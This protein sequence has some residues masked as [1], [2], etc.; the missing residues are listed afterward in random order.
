[1]YFL[2]N[3]CG[4]HCFIIQYLSYIT[5]SLVSK[6]YPSFSIHP[7]NFNKEVLEK[8]GKN[9]QNIT[10]KDLKNCLRLKGQFLMGQKE[11]Q[12]GLAFVWQSH[13]APNLMLQG[14]E[15]EI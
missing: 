1:M 5:A 4:H 10:V 14:Q 13:P 8:L 7:S 2:S 15:E 11:I 6:Q 3:I 9:R 12:S